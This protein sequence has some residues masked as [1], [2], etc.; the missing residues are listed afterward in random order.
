MKSTC[1]L[2]FPLLA[3]A[4][5]SIHTG[6][7]YGAFWGEGSNVKYKDDFLDSFSLARNLKTTVP[8]DSARLFTCIT[9]G[10][11]NDYT[12]AFDA[13]VESKTNLLLGFYTIPS[14]RGISPDAQ[15]KNEMLALEKGFQKHGQALSD[16]VIGLSIGNEDVYHWENARDPNGKPTPG[17]SAEVISATI[18]K[19]RKLIASSTFAKYMQGK[20]IGHVDTAKYAASI[21]GGDFIGMTAYPWW[22]NETIENANTSFHR[23]LEDVK[24]HAGDTPIWIAEMGWPASSTIKDLPEASADDMQKFWTDVGCSVLGRYTTF[25]FELIKDS[26]INQPDWGLLDVSTKQPRIKDLSCP[27]SFP[28]NEPGTPHPSPQTQSSSTLISSSSSSS[29]SLL[30]SLYYLSMKAT[31]PSQSQSQSLQELSQNTAPVVPI[32]TTSTTAS[33][34]TTYTNIASYVTSCTSSAVTST[35]TAT[36]SWCVTQAD[37]YRD[38]NPVIVAGNPAD[39]DGKCIEP[40]QFNGHPYIKHVAAIQSTEVPKDRQW[41]VTIANVYWNGSPVPVDANPAGPDGKCASPPTYNGYP[42]VTVESSAVFHPTATPTNTP[43]LQPAPSATSP[44]AL[45]STPGLMNGCSQSS[46]ASAFTSKS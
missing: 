8:F 34:K 24:Q 30:P 16:L 9:A 22:A 38:G 39:P 33:S 31:S 43:L 45:P 29:S 4:G 46:K 40:P 23:S 25:W 5:S 42:Y 44:A 18:E 26:E 2:F 12:G 1:A 14:V 28:S 6:F 41:C 7:N 17:N 10:T 19:V 15:V 21:K 20:P 36:K 11:Q 3:Q 13:A 37:V 35:K 32:V 27:D